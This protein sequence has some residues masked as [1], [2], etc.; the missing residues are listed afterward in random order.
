MVPGTL[1]WWHPGLAP[2]IRL[3]ISFSNRVSICKYVSIIV[4]MLLVLTNSIFYQFLL[5]HDSHFVLDDF[6][7]IYRDRHSPLA[8]NKLRLFRLANAHYIIIPGSFFIEQIRICLRVIPNIPNAS[9]KIP[10]IYLYFIGNLKKYP[11]NSRKLHR[12][13]CE[14]RVSNNFVIRKRASCRRLFVV[15][16]FPIR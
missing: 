5:Y 13:C 10:A 15:K 14:K 8:M 11:V 7:E 1:D 9:H 6:F 16:Q 3:N 4:I 2:W 12:T